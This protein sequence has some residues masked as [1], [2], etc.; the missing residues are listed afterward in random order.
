MPVKSNQMDRALNVVIVV[1]LAVFA[2]RPEGLLNQSISKW[3]EARSGEKLLREVWPEVVDSR[4]RMG[5]APG[6]PTLVVMTDYQCPFCRTMEDVIDSVMVLNPTAGIVRVNF[7]LE[8]IH[9]RAREAARL[10]VCLEGSGSLNERTSDLYRAYSG[11]NPIELGT[12][13]PR[14]SGE[15]DALLE[16][17][18][19]EATDARVSRDV[20]LSERLGLTGTPGFAVLGVGIHQGTTDARTLSSWLGEGR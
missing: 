16:C 6:G 10:A 17:V 20:Q 7:P 15:P 18:S 5:G 19:S 14:L 3:W 9:P 11:D 13:L 8:S 4:V 2:F 12:L 1:G